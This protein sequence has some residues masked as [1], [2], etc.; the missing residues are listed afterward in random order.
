MENQNNIEKIKTS[1]NEECE[2]LFETMRENIKAQNKPKIGMFWYNPERKRLVG[3]RSTFAHDL[4]FNSKG[5]KTVSDLHH[6]VWNDVREEALANGSPDAIWNEE[7]Y[8]Q[9]PRGRIFQIKV[10][11][12]DAEYFEIL[13]GKWIH[14][15]PEV[16]RLI[17][18]SFNLDET[19]HAFIYSQHW[20]IG[21]GTSELF[22]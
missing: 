22:I 9:V 19:D 11:D 20:D 7:D 4:S 12:S 1:T 2:I 16:T 5:R 10:P 18:K 6:T 15:H 17:L 14:D 8:T 13:V 21:H 3:V